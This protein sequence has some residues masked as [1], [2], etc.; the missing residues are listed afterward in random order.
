MAPFVPT[1]RLATL[2]DQFDD[3]ERERVQL[4]L[5][6]TL[7]ML[8]HMPVE[9][10]VQQYELAE[11]TLCAVE[12]SGELDFRDIITRTPSTPPEE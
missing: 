3:A 4:V 6:Y 5:Q 9:Q 1:D 7:L 11:S 2:L 10:R 8:V 12:D